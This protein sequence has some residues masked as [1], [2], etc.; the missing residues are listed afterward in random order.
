MSQNKTPGHKPSKT[1]ERTP[2]IVNH[3]RAMEIAAA[4][5]TEKKKKAEKR[6]RDQSI[7]DDVDFC[8]TMARAGTHTLAF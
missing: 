1:A 6:L 7:Q 3:K 2:I 8:H 5:A 4:A